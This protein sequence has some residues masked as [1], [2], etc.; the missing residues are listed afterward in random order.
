[1]FT[2][3]TATCQASETRILTEMKR[4]LTAGSYVAIPENPSE[5][6]EPGG[7]PQP[8]APSL[9]GTSAPSLTGDGAESKKEEDTGKQDN[10][11]V[12]ME[13]SGNREGA[14]AEEAEGTTAEEADA[15]RPRTEN[16]EP[17]S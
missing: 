4:L 17:I 8:S 14:T 3:V 9:T 5:V 7:E 16:S 11:R 1:M 15:K 13:I 6:L 10:E 12:P 2:Y